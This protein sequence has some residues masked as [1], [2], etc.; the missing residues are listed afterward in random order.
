[1]SVLHGLAFPLELAV[2]LK[3]SFTV[4]EIR[5]GVGTGFKANFLRVFDRGTES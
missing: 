5:P 2:I 3:G 4:D 1:M